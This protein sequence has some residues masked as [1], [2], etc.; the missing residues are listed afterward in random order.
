VL[1]GTVRPLSRGSI[2]VERRVP[3]GWRVV[4]RPRLD[5]H[6]V[7]NTPLSL[8]PGAYRVSVAGDGRYAAAT[9]KVHVTQRLLATLH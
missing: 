1:S 6:G 5:P 7:F 8:R 4:A 3:G 2:T 9:T